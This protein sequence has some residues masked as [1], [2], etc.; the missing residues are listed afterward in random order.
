MSSLTLRALKAKH[1]DSLLLFTPKTMVLID[2]GPNRVY[3]R[4]LKKTLKSLPKNGEDPPKIDLM[5]ISHIDDDHING[6]LDLMDDLDEARDEDRAPIVDIRRAW[7]N[8]FSD[9]IAKGGISSENEAKD[10]AGTASSIFA[11]FITDRFVDLHDSQAVLASVRQG[12]NLRKFL[13]KFNIATNAH[14]P[15]TIVKLQKPLKPWVKRDLSLTVIG[16]GDTEIN[17]LRKLWAKELKTKILSKGTPASVTFAKS[18]DKSIANLASIVAIAK[19]GSKEILLTGDARGDSIIKWLEKSKLLDPGKSVHFDIIK[20]PHH[21]SDR[22][23]TPAFF[24]R[25]TANHYVACGDGKHGNPEPA[26]FELLFGARPKRDY[27]IHL[28]YTAKEM[29]QNPDFTKHGNDRTFAKMLKDPKNKGVF[30]FPKSG[31]DYLEIK[32]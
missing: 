16:P 9:I 24:K 1:G 31:Q 26:T 32:L 25:V 23:V 29:A 21:G 7:S 18:L 2:G 5:M 20:M 12:R 14:F 30:K 19:A 27:K 15:G 4:V 3:D 6:I 28:T 10:A 22:N 8:S 11:D 17:R 13:H